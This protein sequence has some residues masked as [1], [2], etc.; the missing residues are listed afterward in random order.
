MS[1]TV[2]C[3]I[4][5]GPGA[6]TRLRKEYDVYDRLKSLQG[7]GIPHCYGLFHCPAAVNQACLLLEYG[8]E[9]LPNDA[10]QLEAELPAVMTK[11]L[12]FRKD[13]L[14]I[15][16]RIHKLGVIHGRFYRR[17]DDSIIPK[18]ILVHVK[19]DKGSS[20]EVPYIVNFDEADLAHRCEVEKDVSTRAWGFPLYMTGIY[21]SLCEELVWSANHAIWLPHTILWQAKSLDVG[22]VIY[23]APKDV[24]SKYMKQEL[25]PK[26]A[27]HFEEDLIR[28]RGSLLSELVD[29][30]DWSSREIEPYKN[31]KKELE[32]LDVENGNGFV[33]RKYD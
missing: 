19:E 11:S 1:V 28:E 22:D 7:Q 5:Y 18:N 2:V 30:F 25:G 17:E 16:Q 33:R 6:L 21:D 23:M 3:K 8:G 9:T 15:L 10:S 20:R 4:V 32:E 13:L 31:I 14:D 24:I 26:D 29:C 12:S 27:K